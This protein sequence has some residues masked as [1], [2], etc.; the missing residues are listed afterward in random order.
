MLAT[1]HPA[2]GVRKAAA[3]VLPRDAVTADVLVVNGLLKDPDPHT[4]LAAMLAIAEMPTSAE[5][6]KALYEERRKRNY[7]DRW[8][9]RALYIAATRHKPSFLTSYKKAIRAPWHSK[10]CPFRSGWAHTKPDWRAPAAE[11]LAA[12]GDM[13]VPGNWESRGLPDFDGVVWF[14]R[15]LEWPHGSNPSGLTI[16][17]VSNTSEVSVN[18]LLLTP[19]PAE[20][21]RCTG[22]KRARLRS[23]HLRRPGRHAAQRTE[24]HHRPHPEQPQ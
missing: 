17:R 15:T 20:T 10:T 1:Q 7:S 11:E 3:M 22:G 6:G 5:I 16:G 12:W 4:R 14:T 24:H 8:L 18:G 13:D 9:S 2:A 19:Q 23:A 21:R